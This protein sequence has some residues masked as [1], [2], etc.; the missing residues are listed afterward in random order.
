[1]ETI[2]GESMKIFT[3]TIA[4]CIIPLQIFGG[5]LLYNHV[6]ATDLMW[7]L[8]WFAVPFNVILQVTS[9]MIEKE[10]SK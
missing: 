9:R 3:Y 1:M 10:Q 8:F 5:W 7:F 2:Q 4:F 6:H